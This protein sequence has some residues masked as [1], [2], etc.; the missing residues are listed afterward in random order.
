MIDLSRVAESPELIESVEQAT[1][2]FVKQ[3]LC[4]FDDRE[5]M[6]TIFAR[7]EDL[8]QDV[9]ED[10]TREALDRLGSSSIGVR[11]FGKTD[12]KRARYLF[13]E[14]YSL[15]QALFVDSK[16]ETN[17]ERTAT[18]QTAQTSMRI[19]QRRHGAEIDEAGKL[20]F[21][22][23]SGD[24]QLLTTTI[25][26]KYNY[27]D[28]KGRRAEGANKGVKKLTSVDVFCIPNGILQERY[29]PDVDHGFWGAGRN[30][31]SR[32]EPFRVRVRLADLGRAQPW[33][34]QRITP[35]VVEDEPGLR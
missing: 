7:A 3:A 34:V 15:R 27:S 31:P 2:R 35:G 9:A 1:M 29:N 13:N 33:R 19:R 8:V 5:H 23:T 24:L 12:Y 10:V 22:V 28:V 11:L 6:A 18:I 32:G 30:A 25:F 16:A 21:T 20:P 4:D 17:D 14:E 26:V